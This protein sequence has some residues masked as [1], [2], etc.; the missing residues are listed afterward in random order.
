MTLSLSYRVHVI[1][2]VTVAH[3]PGIFVFLLSGYV[4]I[5]IY[6]SCQDTRGITLYNRALLLK[7]LHLKFRIS[8]EKGGVSSNAISPG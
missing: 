2:F 5:H 4:H 1:T 6:I 3:G 7:A 8:I